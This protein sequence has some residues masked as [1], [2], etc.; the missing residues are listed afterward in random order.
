ADRGAG[1][2]MESQ[3]GEGSAAL[4]GVI[5][6][7][8]DPRAEEVLTEA[9]R[10]MTPAQRIEQAHAM[11]RSIRTMLLCQLRNSRPE[12]SDARVA[13]EVARRMSYGS[14]HRPAAHQ[15]HA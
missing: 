7:Q 9:L 12:W 6:E 11:W 2:S 3:R 13:A 5:P 14:A 4:M 8:C 15:L 1:A 10:A